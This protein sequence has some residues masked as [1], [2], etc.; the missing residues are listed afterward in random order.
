MIRTTFLSSTHGAQ[1]RLMARS[2][3]ADRA[4]ARLAS[5]RAF[6]RASEDPGRATTALALRGELN[7]L[8]SYQATAED[9]RTRLDITD[10]QLSDAAA[11][12]GRLKELAVA[13]STG[14]MNDTGRESAAL[15][16]E[17]IRDQLVGLAN[18][19]YVDQP[20]FAGFSGGLAVE[21]TGAPAAWTF[22]GTPTE[23]IRRA[24]SDNDVV[25]VNITAVEV[26]QAG[27]GDVFTMLDELAA[28]LRANDQSAMRAAI[29]DI[30]VF[31]ASVS[32]AR[33]RIGVA[34]NRV[35]TVLNTNLARQTSIQADL[36]KAEDI[37]LVEGITDV[38]RQQAAY[39]AALGATAKSLQQSLVDFLR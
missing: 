39:Q 21:K 36:S 5:G 16:I 38:N 14:T 20:L 27:S 23:Q 26:F 33:S 28:D 24:V 9:A 12:V 8:R 17:G 1:Q 22:T 18:A 13:A 25:Q 37:D 29:D 7:A 32:T 2:V 34:T 31:R 6:T 19:S 15:E 10:G 4:S 35:E 11:L 3:A 30:E